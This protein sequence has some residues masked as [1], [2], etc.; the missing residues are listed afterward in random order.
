[1]A[2]NGIPGG[3]AGIIKDKVTSDGTRRIINNAIVGTTEDVL[4]SNLAEGVSNSGY[5]CM[6]GNEV[7]DVVWGG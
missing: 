1:M 2:N 3:I 7:C 5:G 6:F 4:A